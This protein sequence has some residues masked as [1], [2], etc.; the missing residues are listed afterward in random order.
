MPSQTATCPPGCAWQDLRSD[1]Q[2]EFTQLDLELAFAD[3]DAI[4]AMMERLMSAVFA[5]VRRGYACM[6][7]S[8]RCYPMSL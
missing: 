3:S 4:M 5:E 7:L 1:R 6:F 2:P 8:T